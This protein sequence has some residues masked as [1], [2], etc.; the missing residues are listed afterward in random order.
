MDTNFKGAIFDFDG[1]LVRSSSA[2]EN[3]M[4]GFFN[5][6]NLVWSDKL[7]DFNALTLLECAQRIVDCYDLDETAV[8]IVREWSNKV[9]GEYAKLKFMP[10]CYDYIVKLY[11]SG[12]KIALATLCYKK[13][14]TETLR[15]NG[16]LHMFS[17]II[18]DEDVANGNKRYPD[19]Y[20]AAAKA[21]DVPPHDCHVF[22]DLAVAVN[23]VRAAGM[24]CTLIREHGSAGDYNP[25]P[26]RV[27][28]SFTELA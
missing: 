4:G 16:V 27:I 11:S 20:L 14:A 17:A 5:S 12:I 1:T 18:T 3:V 23:G 9:E 8:D 6:R 10:G 7:G 15:A 2:W 28:R 25:Q 19:I 21:I 24:G 13:H 26:D 22:E